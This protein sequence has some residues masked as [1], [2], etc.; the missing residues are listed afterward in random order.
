VAIV[1]AETRTIVE[2]NPAALRMLGASEAE[3]IVGRPCHGLLCAAQAGMCRVAAPL[4]RL[5]NA[6]QTLVTL[7]GERVPVL[8]TVVPMMVN[9]REQLLESFLDTSEL[10]GAREEARRAE[11]AKGEFLA[12]VSHEIRTPMNGILGMTR[13]ALETDLTPEQ[14]EYL[15]MAR[16]SAASLLDLINDILDLS[17]LEARRLALEEIGFDLRCSLEEAARGLASRAHEKGLELSWRVASN[18]PEALVGDPARL[19]QVILHLAGNAIKFTDGGEVAVN[20]EV[21]EETVDAATLLFT[22]SDTGAGMTPESLERAFDAFAQADGST[23]RRHGGAGL[24]LSISR[25]L[26]G[27]MG[28]RIWAESEVGRGSRFC[29]TVRLAL[30]RGETAGVH[31][32]HRALLEGLR[33]LIA[34]HES[35]DRETLCE[36]M[37]R[38]GLVH[39]EAAGG[40][41]TIEAAEAACGRREA[42]DLVL[43]ALQMPDMDG[44]EVAR[45]LRDAPGGRALPVIAL[46][47]VGLRGDAL[48][49]RKLGLAGYLLKPVRATELLDAVLATLRGRGRANR[50]FV[51]RHSLREARRRTEPG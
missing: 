27:L 17:R 3:E 33:V 22:I 43:L 1:D 49:C 12:N 45:R 46:A 50:S 11:R 39:S 34:D 42:F 19:R 2:A 25:R 4:A 7:S 47:S 18:V 28:G 14:R 29:F 38:W 44:F 40:R 9:G 16:S 15:E 31:A 8:K 5:E 32:P 20:V 30:Q 24:G 48:R 21:E 41:E 6:E 35:A 10:Q 23:T 36:T 13:L 51:T 26:I 37:A